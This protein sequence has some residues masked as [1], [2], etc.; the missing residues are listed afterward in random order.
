MLNGSLAA[1]PV[2]SVYR[3][4]LGGLAIFVQ[5]SASYKQNSNQANQ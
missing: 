3:Y 5:Y 1:R 4:S 2:H